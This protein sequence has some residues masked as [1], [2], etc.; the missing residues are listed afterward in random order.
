MNNIQDDLYYHKKQEYKPIMHVCPWNCNSMGPH[1]M[2]TKLNLSHLVLFNFYTCHNLFKKKKKKDIR[3]WAPHKGTL[4]IWFIRPNMT[5]GIN[6]AKSS[7]KITYFTVYKCQERY[8]DLSPC[9]CNSRSAHHHSHKQYKPKTRMP[10]Y[11]C[12]TMTTQRLLQAINTCGRTIYFIPGI[13]YLI[14]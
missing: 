3:L 13:S 10:N 2:C 14:L 8:K 7:E 1:S 11:V 6:K 12:G 9:I 4:E 5:T